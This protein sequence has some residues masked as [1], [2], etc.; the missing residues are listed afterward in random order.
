M[1]FPRISKFAFSNE[2]LCKVAVISLLFGLIPFPHYR[3]SCKNSSCFS[4]LK[5]LLTSSASQS[6]KD[7][8]PSQYCSLPVF[9]Q[10]L[11]ISTLPSSSISFL[12]L[13]LPEVILSYIYTA[14]KS[15]LGLQSGCLLWFSGSEDFF[16][17]SIGHSA[18]SSLL[19]CFQHSLWSA[20]LGTA[21]R[22]SLD[23]YQ[24]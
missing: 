22:A 1:H 5:P 7:P 9:V 13:L 24:A 19:C 23:L 21:P 4:L 6:V 11:H 18:F 16:T 10:T 15:Q 17:T 14:P 20:K 3:K 12:I 2:S 8:F